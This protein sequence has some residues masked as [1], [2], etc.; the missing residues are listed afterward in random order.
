MMVRMIKIDSYSPFLK[1][2]YLEGKLNGE[3]VAEALQE[4]SE[5]ISQT[6]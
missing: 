3:I 2:A 6:R 1:R 4:G 5:V